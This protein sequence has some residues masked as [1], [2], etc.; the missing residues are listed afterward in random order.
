MS[1]D[2]LKSANKI[3]K[4]KN[5]KTIFDSFQ[6]CIS[7]WWCSGVILNKRRP[8]PVVRRVILNTPTC[9]I[10]DN[11]N[12]QDKTGSFAAGW[13]DA[14]M[15]NQRFDVDVEFINHVDDPLAVGDNDHVWYFKRIIKGG[16]ILQKSP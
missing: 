4:I 6:S 16:Q 9:N 1:V 14:E 8:V 10:T 13:E 15:G 3:A 2:K 5:R 7:K 11:D 12:V